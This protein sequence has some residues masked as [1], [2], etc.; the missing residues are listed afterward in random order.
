MRT[1][2]PERAIESWRVLVK[3]EFTLLDQ[4]DTDG[5]RY[6]VARANAPDARGPEVLTARERQVVQLASLGYTNKVIAYSLG[7][8]GSTVRVLVSRAATR[9][10][11]ATREE[12]VSRFRALALAKP[13]TDSEET[14]ESSQVVKRQEAARRHSRGRA[15]RAD[16]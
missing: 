8:S 4:F 11:A 16:T 9:L 15:G 1:R 2:D 14:V 7:L 13:A 3:A 10:G 6:I 12:L 5:K